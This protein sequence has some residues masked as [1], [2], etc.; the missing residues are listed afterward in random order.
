MQSIY[1][2]KQLAHSLGERGYLYTESG[3]I[4]EISQHVYEI[5]K[6][7]KQLINNNCGGDYAEQ[8]RAMAHH[9]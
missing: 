6:H 2:T 8:T 1:M 5:E 3:D 4:P 7:Y 9:V